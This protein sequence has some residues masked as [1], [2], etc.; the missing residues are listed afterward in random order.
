MVPSFLHVHVPFR[1]VEMYLPSL[2]ERR[3]QPELGL[4]AIDLD[5]H[6]PGYFTNLGARFQAASLAVTVHAPFMDLNPGAVEP[7]VQQVTLQRFLQTLDAADRLAARLVVFH[8]GY[9]SWRYGKQRRAWLQQALHFWPQ[10][11]V[12]AERLGIRL[13]LENIYD[14][15]SVLLREQVDGLDHPSFGHCFDIG[16]WALFGKP[17]LTEWLQSLDT[18]LF[19]LHLHDNF[20]RQDDHLPVGAGQ[21]DFTPLWSHLTETGL[22]PSITLEA[23]SQ[24]HLDHSLAAV[25][26]LLDA[27]N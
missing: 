6:E 20:G 8:P 22:R 19:H 25:L 9:D 12:R 16:H 17:T 2:L 11:C 13:A 15:D 23:H 4:Q 5:L 21:I 10:L 24:T 1:Q 3:L 26:P 18:K 7:L 27:L 14:E